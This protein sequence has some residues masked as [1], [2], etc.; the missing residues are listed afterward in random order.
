M[1]HPFLFFGCRKTKTQTKPKPKTKAETPFGISAV[2][3]VCG[4]GYSPGSVG[5]WLA[6]LALMAMSLAFL[7]SS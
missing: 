1:G 7:N 2:T 6:S 5:C 3:S 4:R